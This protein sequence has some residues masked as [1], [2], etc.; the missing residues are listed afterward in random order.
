M[1]SVNKTEENKDYF[2]RD[3]I[4]YRLKTQR[5]TVSFVWSWNHFD[6]YIKL[7]IKLNFKPL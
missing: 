3:I 7:E 1:L 6:N 5:A 4:K 2:I